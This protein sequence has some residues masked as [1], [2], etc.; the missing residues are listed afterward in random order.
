MFFYY[1]ICDKLNF[2][3][4]KLKKLNKLKEK[5]FIIIKEKKKI[6]IQIK[7]FFYLIIYENKQKEKI[8]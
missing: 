6:I 3:F 1:F 2:I 5:K 4:L 8:K 7:I